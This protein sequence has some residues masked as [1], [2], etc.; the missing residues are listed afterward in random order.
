MICRFMFVNMETENPWKNRNIP[1]AYLIN[2]SQAGM[3][4]F[5]SE[6]ESRSQK[7]EREGEPLRFKY[8]QIAR[9][10]K[11]KQGPHLIS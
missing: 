6:T 9:F 1:S 3:V 2:V 11:Q 10:F 5:L 4:L 7:P 8:V